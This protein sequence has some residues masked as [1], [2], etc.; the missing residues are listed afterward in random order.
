MEMAWVLVEEEE[1]FDVDEPDAA[2][3]PLPDELLAPDADVVCPPKTD[4]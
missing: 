1:L 2:V 3:L 4:P